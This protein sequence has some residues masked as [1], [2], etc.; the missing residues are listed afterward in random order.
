ME[1]SDLSEAGQ[2]F[3]ALT[4]G[5]YL[6]DQWG[7]DWRVAV[8]QYALMLDAETANL[9]LVDL[10]HLLSLPLPIRDGAIRSWSVLDFGADCSMSDEYLRC[11]VSAC[12]S[13]RR[14]QNE[15][16]ESWGQALGN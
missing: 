1:L 2:C 7:G 3:I 10:R 9:V 15:K 16:N 6:F 4:L 12:M 11:A 5:E 8:E 14:L 13:V